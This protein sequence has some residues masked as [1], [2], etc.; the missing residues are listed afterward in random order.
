[1]FVCKDGQAS[2]A[3]QGML[4]TAQ[5]GTHT[6][7]GSGVWWAHQALLGT[8]KLTCTLEVGGQSLSF[9]STLTLTPPHIAKSLVYSPWVV[10]DSPPPNLRSAQSGEKAPHGQKYLSEL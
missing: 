3:S 1:M 10:M 5:L 7:S 6:S 2:A 8:W 4:E 9:Y